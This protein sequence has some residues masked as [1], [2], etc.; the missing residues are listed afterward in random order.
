MKVWDALLAGQKLMEQKLN[1]EE[2]DKDTIR[3]ECD[4]LL[5]SLL[6]WERHELYLNKDSE[7]D[8]KIAGRFM[9]MINQRLEY[10]PVQYLTGT[11]EF[12][13]LTFMVDQRVLIPRSDTEVLV[14]Y[15]INYAK[16]LNTN[17]ELIN[18]KTLKSGREENDKVLEDKVLKILDIGTGS[19]AIA[20]SL[21][22][23][24]HNARV[25]A[26]DISSDALEVARE[27]A[28]KNDVSQRIAFINGDLFDPLE[29]QFFDIIVS[30]PPYIRK[31]DIDGLMPEV[32]DYEPFIALNGG[33]DGLDFYRRIA[34][35]AYKFLV[36]GGLI[37]LEIGFDQGE[38]VFYLL[39]SQKTYTAPII[40]KDL[41]GH[42]RVVAA[43]KA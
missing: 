19:G 36:P 1:D 21:A 17:K 4:M 14:E 31:G 25:T 42:D 38:S 24:I 15:V 16:A 9:D 40:I 2:L 11:K 10:K 32:K 34:A 39:E 12:M 5:A 13:G 29:G 20:V 27:N 28:K 6:S 33:D 18:E 43:K 35:N 37:A 3:L 30:N 7:L 26:V 23:Y 22:K 8:D 41:S